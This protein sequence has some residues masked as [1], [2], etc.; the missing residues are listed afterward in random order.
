MIQI[1]LAAQF[2]GG[3]LWHFQ[4]SPCEAGFLV[5][6]RPKMR[7]PPFNSKTKSQGSERK[8]LLKYF[9][10]PSF[11]A[12]FQLNRLTTTFGPWNTFADNDT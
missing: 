4:N 9:I 1:H 3:V 5:L 12:K 11:C 6:K 7:P 8:W 10:T 2:T